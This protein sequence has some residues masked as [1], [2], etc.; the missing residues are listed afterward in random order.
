MEGLGKKKC[1]GIKN[2]TYKQKKNPSDTDNSTVVTEG[3]GVAAGR[4][5]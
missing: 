1:E 5:G 3:K 2:K 4:R